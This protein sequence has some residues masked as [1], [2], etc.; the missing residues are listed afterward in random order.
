VRLLLVEHLHLLLLLLLTYLN[1]L[2]LGILFLMHLLRLQV[3]LLVMVVHIAKELV[4][5]APARE[6]SG[7]PAITAVVAV[8]IL[9]S[10]TRT[11]T[12]N[13]MLGK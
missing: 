10:K 13:D 11:G 9:I 3:L 12:H 5:A 2:L 7:P 8:V 4:A 6:N 1:L